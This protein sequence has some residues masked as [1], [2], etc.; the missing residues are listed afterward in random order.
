M[1][2]LMDENAPAPD[3]EGVTVTELDA[4]GVPVLKFTP[5]GASPDLAI[6]HFHGGGYRLGSPKGF[7]RYFARVAKALGATVYAPKYRLAPENPYPA[8]IKDAVTV[9][10][11]LLAQGLPASG[12]IPGGDSAGGGLA[13]ALLLKIK[14][15]GLPSPGGAA[16][17]SAWA[18]VRITSETFTSNAESDQLFPRERAE[19]ASSL[20]LQGADASDPYASPVLGDWSGQPPLLIHVSNLET[21]LADSLTI[22]EKASAAGVPVRLERFDGVQHVWH[23]AYPD[24]AESQ[25]AVENWRDWLSSLGLTLAPSPLTV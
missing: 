23:N 18:D 12:I 15:L 7:S 10:Q 19:Q 11:Y 3:A 2:R 24:T 16:L 9:Y 25:R 5:E 4:D 17:F 13:A 1:R 20:F 14:E 6:L 22:A 21:L 8:A